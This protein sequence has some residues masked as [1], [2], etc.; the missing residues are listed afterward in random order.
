MSKEHIYSSLLG[1]REY[2]DSTPVST[3]GEAIFVFRVG[4]QDE[5]PDGYVDTVCAEI[6]RIADFLLSAGQVLAEAV[7]SWQNGSRQLGE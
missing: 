4:Q 2:I 6:Q 5:T 7:Q 1:W 3:F